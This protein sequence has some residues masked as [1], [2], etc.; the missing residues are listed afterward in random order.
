VFLIIKKIEDYRKRKINNL[1]ETK[2]YLNYLKAVLSAKIANMKK[3]EDNK[4]EDN[5]KNEENNKI[6]SLQKEIKDQ[7]KLKNEYVNDILTLKSA[8]SIIDE[9]FIKEIE[10]AEI[11]KKYWLRN[12]FIG[13]FGSNFLLD[14]FLNI[15]DPKELNEFVINIM[16][17][18][19][20]EIDVKINNKLKLIAQKLELNEQRYKD[21][22]NMKQKID[23]ITIKNYK[24]TNE[25]I[26]KNIA[27][28]QNIY[29]KIE[30]GTF[31][32]NKDP[33]KTSTFINLFDITNS[34]KKHDSNNNNNNSNEYENSIICYERKYSDS[35]FSDMDINVGTKV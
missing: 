1:K 21:Y 5:D 13:L 3:N 32:R 26:N 16:N 6:K 34:E 19:K 11:K 15:K 18:H 2:N 14:T 25:L 4:M 27:L 10:N 24:L 20:D 17:P 7:Y 30:E 22:K 35:D 33:K 23:E 8:F 28:S 31:S 12:Y 29:N 9:M